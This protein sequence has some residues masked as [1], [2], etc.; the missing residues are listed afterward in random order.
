M[1]IIFACL[2][3]LGIVRFIGMG[4]GNKSPYIFFGGVSLVACM[5]LKQLGSIK[6]SREG[7]GSNRKHKWE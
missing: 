3:S 5:T 2:M 6:G 1:P 7:W 4:T